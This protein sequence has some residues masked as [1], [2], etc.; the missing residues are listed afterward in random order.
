MTSSVLA[1][2]T[3]RHDPA[4]IALPTGVGKTAVANALPYALATTGRVLV[5]E[6]SIVLRKQAAEEF[7]TLYRLKLVNVLNRPGFG[8]HSRGCVATGV[9]ETI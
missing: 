4:I 5:I 9:V 2:F 7:R 8:G 3:V 6:P 1:H